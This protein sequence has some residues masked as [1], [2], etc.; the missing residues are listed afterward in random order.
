[1]QFPN[2]PYSA[3]LLEC[4]KAKNRFVN[5]FPCKINTFNLLLSWPSFPRSTLLTFPFLSDDH[6]RVTLARQGDVK[7]SDDYINASFVDVRHLIV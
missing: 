1:M 6:N 4:N 2:V 3:S 7:G 5:I